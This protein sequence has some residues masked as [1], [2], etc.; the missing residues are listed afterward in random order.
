MN[1]LIRFQE[2]LFQ[3]AETHSRYLF[4]KMAGEIKGYSQRYQQA[5]TRSVDASSPQEFLSEVGRR[6][7]ILLGD[8]H[9]LA[10]SQACALEVLQALQNEGKRP[11][12][13][14]EMFTPQDAAALK[15]FLSHGWSEGAFLKATRIEARWPFPWENYRALLRF[16]RENKC[17]VLPLSPLKKCSLKERDGYAANVIARANSESNVVALVGEFHLA[18][19]HLPRLLQKHLPLEQMLVLHQSPEAVAWKILKEGSRNYS[20]FGRFADSEFW[21]LRSAPWQKLS[22]TLVWDEW[23]QAVASQEDPVLEKKQLG[24]ELSAEWF[25]IISSECFPKISEWR[26]WDLDSLAEA[27]SRC[28]FSN[29]ANWLHLE[30]LSHFATRVLNP[31]KKRIVASEWLL[32]GREGTD[33]LHWKKRF[34][35]GNK[36]ELHSPFSRR[37]IGEWLGEKL[38]D[39]IFFRNQQQALLAEPLQTL[40]SVLNTTVKSSGFRFAA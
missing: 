21:C 20:G 23:K 1:S 14:L 36:S 24:N 39:R 16:A 29:Q 34:L 19:G 22:S 32:H 31:F 30:T 26:D 27:G 18:P 10:S 9:T 35:E 28:F 25:Q 33:A 7:C 11:T 12:L 2:A 40:F 17:R 15:G 8:H 6:Q 13:C 37:L 4:G 3:S 5:M 38:F